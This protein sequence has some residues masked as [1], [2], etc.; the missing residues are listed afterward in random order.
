MDL[1]ESTELGTSQC[2]FLFIFH[3]D[4]KTYVFIPSNYRSKLKIIYYQHFCESIFIIINSTLA[5]WRHKTP[6]HRCSHSIFYFD[7]I[8]CDF[9]DFWQIS[10]FFYFLFVAENIQITEMK[11]STKDIIQIPDLLLLQSNWQMRNN[12][13]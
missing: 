1:E 2:A 13:Y 12:I 8:S 5:R 6:S 7:K 10:Y 4:A 9:T 11:R 3:E